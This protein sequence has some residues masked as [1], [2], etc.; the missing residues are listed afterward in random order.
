[1]V[2]I[3]FSLIPTNNAHASTDIDLLDQKSCQTAPLSGIWN[4]TT[5]TCIISKLRLSSDDSLTVDNSIFSNIALTITGYVNNDG[6]ITNS[7]IININQVGTIDNYGKIINNQKSL[8]INS[9]TFT[10][11][12]FGVIINNG[13]TITN[14]ATLNQII[15]SAITNSG[16]VKN[17]CGG[18]FT[19]DGNFNGNPVENVT[20]TTTSKL[21]TVP[22]FPFALP[23]LVIGILSVIAFYRTKSKF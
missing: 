19:S 8:I 22:E 1:V 18:S 15:R 10:I 14:Y 13:G 6:T 5:S 21:S 16:I 23:A 4:V 12:E 11:N 9:G 2:L 3:F 20:C 17:M 7:G